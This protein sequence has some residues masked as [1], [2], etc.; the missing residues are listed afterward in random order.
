MKKGIIVTGLPASGKTTVARELATKLGF[1]FLDKDDFLEDLYDSRGVTSWEHR[2]T[3]SRESDLI[4]MSAARRQGNVVL[5][6]HWRPLGQSGE[7]GTPTEWLS[8]TYDRLIEVTCLCPVETAIARFTKRA[9][10]PGHMDA[11]RDADE[12]ATRFAAWAKLF[13][14]GLGIQI[15]V[16]TDRAVD[17]VSLS[18]RTR[19]ALARSD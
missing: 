7:S 5:V 11:Q 6:S 1:V 15:E 4:F 19:Q 2:K 17:M 10:H 3:L 12:L 9:R 14:I 8:D 16:A 13:P 18:R